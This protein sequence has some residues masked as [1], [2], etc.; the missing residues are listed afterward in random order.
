MLL[1]LFIRF[2]RSG[3]LIPRRL[4]RYTEIIHSFGTASVHQLALG[5][6][7]DTLHLTRRPRPQTSTRGVRIRPAMLDTEMNA[8]LRS[9]HDERMRRSVGAFVSDRTESPSYIEA[10]LVPGRTDL[11]RAHHTESPLASSVSACYQTLP[12]LV[13]DLDGTLLDSTVPGTRP[14]MP[15]FTVDGVIE[16]RLRPGLGAFLVA[17]RSHFDLAVF[18]AGNASYAEQMISGIDTWVPGF[19]ASLRR[20]YSRDHVDFTFENRSIRVTKDLRRLARDCGL[21]LCRCLIVDDT[22]DTYRLNISNALPVPVYDGSSSD[23]TLDRLRD[24]LLSMPKHGVP[25]DVRGWPL[26]PR[27][28]QPL[29]AGNDERAAGGSTGG[30]GGLCWSVSTACGR[31]HLKRPFSDVAPAFLPA[32]LPPPEEDKMVF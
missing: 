30:H 32:F 22:P 15:T 21:P 5:P 27:G 19:R 29:L 24:F 6:T 3:A 4:T 17:V 16:T 26:A 23:D 28:A 18:T 10:D 9:L 25:L 2:A 13:L 7:R 1:S 8:L 11:V 31:E 20:V 12:L 14:G